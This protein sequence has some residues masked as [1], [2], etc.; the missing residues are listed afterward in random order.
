MNPFMEKVKEYGR[1]KWS[2]GLYGARFDKL[3]ERREEA[4]ADELLKEIEFHHDA[5]LLI[6]LEKFQV[7]GELRACVEMLKEVHEKLW[8]HE[9][10]EAFLGMRDDLRDVIE[11]AESALLKTGVKELA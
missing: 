9:D 7:R 8:S 4:E 10:D 3:S 1:L 5:G 6:A 11:S 2:E